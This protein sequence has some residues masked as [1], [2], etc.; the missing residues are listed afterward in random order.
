[1]F[2]SQLQHIPTAASPDECSN[3][4]ELYGDFRVFNEI[5][6]EL[7]ASYWQQ[8]EDLGRTFGASGLA[9]QLLSVP[10]DFDQNP[11]NF[12]AQ[13]DELRQRIA[14]RGNPLQHASTFAV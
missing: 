13:L 12:M 2:C 4:Y 11:E 10:R 9:L 1:V 14:A 3:L 8:R 5:K 6:A 7:G